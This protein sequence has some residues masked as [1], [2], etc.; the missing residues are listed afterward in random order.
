MRP[1]RPDDTRDAG[2]TLVEFLVAMAIVAM[3][4]A[5]VGSTLARRDGRA[6]PMEVGQA[7]QSMLMR[8]RSDAIRRGADTVFVLDAGRRS[9]TYPADAEPVVLPDGMSIRMKAGGEF[10]SG[11]GSTYSLV[12]RAD[13][14]A[15]GAEIVLGDG[16]TR[17]A[18]ID[19]HW[20]TG[21][22]RLSVAEVP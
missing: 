2:F 11:D 18:R 16:G 14:S 13:G 10:V 9:Y 6:S 17:G 22:P 1:R 4:A 21:V 5:S 19:V 12:F 15:S 20:L 3:V 7:M 8:A